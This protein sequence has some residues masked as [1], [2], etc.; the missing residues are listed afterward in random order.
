MARSSVGR[1]VTGALSDATGRSDEEIR[2]GLTLSVT[3]AVLGS[4]LVAALRVIRSLD[5][6]GAVAA[7]HR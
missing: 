5:R 3:A 7:G 1:R 2:L 4:C 6:L